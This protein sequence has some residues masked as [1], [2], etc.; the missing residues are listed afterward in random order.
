MRDLTVILQ[1]KP[2]TLAD[3]GEALGRANINM[4]G[5]C[6]FPCEGEGVIHI[7]VEDAASARN[8][9]EE[10]GFEVRAEREVIIHELD[11]KP[12]TLGEACRRLANAGVNIDLLYGSYKG[13]VFGVDDLDKARA[14]L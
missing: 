5:L 11:D 8:V 7:V 3:M 13:A 9:L 6:G 14:S 1:N 12:G 4:E 2:G 10:A